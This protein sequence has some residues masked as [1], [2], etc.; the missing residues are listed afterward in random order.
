MIFPKTAKG[1]VD[2]LKYIKTAAE[3]YTSLAK[4]GIKDADTA[5]FQ[6]CLDDLS[7]ADTMQE[8]KKKQ[9]KAATSARNATLKQLDD[10]MYQM[11]AAA[12]IE[13]ENEPDILDEFK[14]IIKKSVKKKS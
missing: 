3:N 13:F 11:R 7:A 1:I 4:R 2:G 10:A 12:A 6:K 9:G 8:N 5:N 14:S